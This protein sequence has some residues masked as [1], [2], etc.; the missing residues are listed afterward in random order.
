MAEGEGAAGCCEGRQCYLLAANIQVF[1]K[2]LG[3][4]VQ[5]EKVLMT[6]DWS[7]VRIPPE[8]EIWNL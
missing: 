1:P 8:V 5:K 6:Q 4:A 2:G 3:M 7:L